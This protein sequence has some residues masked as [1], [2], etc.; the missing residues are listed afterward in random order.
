MSSTKAKK[1]LAHKPKTTLNI[2]DKVK[3]K[4]VKRK[5]KKVTTQE[6]ILG[7]LGIGSTLI[8]GVSQVA[9]QQQKTEFVSS[10]KTQ[11]G[12]STSKVR[13]TL[14]K[15][16]KSSFGIPEA[17][18]DY[19][20]DI[21]AANAAREAAYTAAAAAAA[22]A[23]AANNQWRAEAEAGIPGFAEEDR[24][25]RQTDIDNAYN[26]EEVNIQN[27]YNAAAAAADA[28]Y[29]AAVTAA[30]ATQAQIDAAAA[31]AA[32]AAAQAAAAAAAAQ[33]QAEALAAAQAAAVAAAAAAAANSPHE[34]DSGTIEGRPAHYHML[35]GVMT[36]VDDQGNSVL[37]SNG[38][39]YIADG[40]GGW[41]LDS[42][43]NSVRP[44]VDPIL[45]THAQGYTDSTHP[46]QHWNATDLEGHGAWANDE[47]NTGPHEND[48]GTIDV[49][50]QGHYHMLNGIM[51]LVDDQ[52]NRVLNPNGLYYR[53]DGNGGWN[54]D[55]IQDQPSGPQEGQEGTID[56]RLAHYH[57]VNGVMTLV[58]DAGHPVLNP[59]GYYYTSDGNNGWTLNDGQQ[60]TENGISYHSSG[61]QWVPDQ[62]AAG[63]PFAGAVFTPVYIPQT[64]T[65]WADAFNFITGNIDKVRDSVNINAATQAMNQVLQKYNSITPQSLEEAQA[66]H[67]I[68]C[69]II[70]DLF[71][72]VPFILDSSRSS[73]WQ[74]VNSTYLAQINQTYAGQAASISGA[75][76]NLQIF[77]TPEGNRIVGTAEWGQVTVDPNGNL[78]STEIDPGYPPPQSLLD[79]IKTGIHFATD[80]VPPVATTNP[81]FAQ[82]TVFLQDLV[83]GDSFNYS[84]RPS[85]GSGNFS[86]ALDASNLPPGLSLNASTGVISGT[87]TTAGGYPFTVVATDSVS[88]KTASQIITIRVAARAGE[89]PTT[90]ALPGT[91][92]ASFTLADPIARTLGLSTTAPVILDGNV[93]A[94]VI[95]IGDA[96]Y[97]FKDGQYV[98]I[99][100]AALANGAPG[101]IMGDRY[102]E[103]QNGQYVLVAQGQALQNMIETGS[104]AFAGL[105]A[106]IVVANLSAA[107]GSAGTGLIA[108]VGSAA[109]SG[110][111]SVFSTVGSTLG[112]GAWGTTAAAVGGA[113]IIGAA[114]VGT[115][116][117][118]QAIL[119]RGQDKVRDTHRIEDAIPYFNQ[120]MQQYYSIT[121]ATPEEARALN[122]A[123]KNA[124]QQL[125]NQIPFEKESSKVDQQRWLQINY[126][127]PLDQNLIERNMAFNDFFTNLQVFETPTGTRIA[128]IGDWGQIRVDQNG[129]LLSY[130]NITNGPPP[131]SVL[132]AIQNASNVT[133]IGLTDDIT[134][135]SS[136]LQQ[137]VVGAS[138]SQILSVNGGSGPF[139][140]QVIGGSLPDG[141]VLSQGGTISGEPSVVGDFSFKIQ[142]SD[143]AGKLANKDFNI[144]VA[145]ASVVASPIVLTS[146][147]PNAIVGTAYNGRISASGGSG[148][149]Y[150]YV[151]VGGALP[152][153]LVFNQDGTITG[154]TLAGPNSYSFSVEVTDSDQNIITGSFQ[155]EVKSANDPT[156]NRVNITTA[157]ILPEPTKNVAYSAT[158]A[159]TGGTGSFVYSLQSGSLP[160]GLS[161]NSSS[162]TISGTPTSTGDFLFD[163]KVTDT[164]DST[165]F[166][167]KPFRI[168]VNPSAVAAPVVTGVTFSKAT[169]ERGGS[170]TVSYQGTNLQS[171]YFDVLVTAPDGSRV[172]ADNWQPGVKNVSLQDALGTFTITG[173]RAHT[174]PMVHSGAFQNL[175]ASI[176]VV[177]A[178]GGSGFGTVELTQKE[179]VNNSPYLSD[180]DGSFRVGFQWQLNFRGTAG[181]HVYVIGG[182]NGVGTITDGGVIGPDGTLKISGTFTTAQIGPWQEDWYIGNDPVSA[183]QNKIGS[184]AFRITDQALAN[185]PYVINGNGTKSFFNPADLS[186]REEVDYFIRLFGLPANTPVADHPKPQLTPGGSFVSK[187]VY[188]VTPVVQNGRTVLTDN[189]DRSFEIQIQGQWINVGLIRQVLNSANNSGIY[190]I[191]FWQALGLNMPANIAA[192]AAAQPP[193]VDQ[194][195]AN[196]GLV[197]PGGSYTATF[198]GSNLANTYF[199]VKVYVGSTATAAAYET[200]ILNWQRGEIGSHIV[201]ANHPDQVLTIIAVRAHNLENDHS[202]Q[203]VQLPQI[204]SITITK[205]IPPV[206]NVP[207]SQTNQLPPAPTLNIPTP[208]VA[209]PGGWPIGSI[210]ATP[211]GPVIVGPNGSTT[212]YTGQTTSASSPAI[213]TGSNLGNNP[214]TSSPV[215]ISSI[216]ARDTNGNNAN[217]ILKTGYTIEIGGN[218]LSGAYSGF[219]MVIN[220]VDVPITRVVTTNNKITLSPDFPANLANNT[221]IQIKLK[222]NVAGITQGV[223]AGATFLYLTTAP[224]GTGAGGTTGAGTGSGSTGSSGT[225]TGSTGSGTTGSGTG[226]GSGTTGSGSTGSGPGT[227]ATGTGSTGTGTGGTGS[228]ST[229]SGTGTSGSGTGAGTGSTGGY[230]AQ[231]QGTY[232]TLSASSLNLA[233]NGYGTVTASVL[234]NGTINHNVSAVTTSTNIIINVNQSSGIISVVAVAVGTAN[235]LV[236]P[237]NLPASDVS[238]DKIINVFISGQAGGGSTGGTG[239]GSTGGGTSGTGGT[240]TGGTTSTGSGTTSGTGS[241]GS[242]STGTGSG[243]TGGS[244][245]SGG[246]TNTSTAD[247]QLIAQLQSQVTNLQ[248]R[249]N[250]LTNRLANQ[251]GGGGGTIVVNS[252]DAAQLTS[253]QN[254]VQQL[255]NLVQNLQSGQ[256][257]FNNA[258]VQPF[259][260]LQMPPGYGVSGP[261]T[262][263]GSSSGGLQMPPGYGA[264]GDNSAGQT[265]ETGTLATYKVKKGDNLWNI[266]KKYYGSGAQWRKLLAAN[267]K[268][269]S[270]PGNTRTLRIGFVLNIPQ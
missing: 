13:E 134:I 220:G 47:V 130:E 154:T 136:A 256:V 74:W 146:T 128:S 89:Q 158:I 188:D 249:I 10:Q 217:G 92:P 163:I 182:L 185:T 120:I 73:Q 206:S 191:K 29:S 167:S 189:G 121:P 261:A 36:L 85:G 210:I 211:A 101:I 199:D 61:G 149:G 161:L 23:R 180:N 216:V 195:S 102:Y 174:D 51:T 62:P 231:V 228:G 113:T 87:L 259:Q 227:G 26:Q 112:I 212:P 82:A 147:L 104:G 122:E 1:Y 132:R 15:I 221:V 50:R 21:A 86:F 69:Q 234:Y 170:Y 166:A 6:K 162:G 139:A 110:T 95:V 214:T 60:K 56:T 97:Q 52:G 265:Q 12:S 117:V 116:V 156:A 20:S 49:N 251:S 263:S 45:E 53:A 106:G 8:G 183:L 96:F 244:G 194:L 54:L 27:N 184:L 164:T 165:N 138:Y 187:Y 230:A 19:N 235:I 200:E 241:G 38:L 226:T 94:S 260:G 159:A 207:G 98:K 57:M 242:G 196:T 145:E 88:Q 115:I 80:E 190:D 123:A 71:N 219:A 58:E 48:P 75:L 3:I 215:I 7:G 177:A 14:R 202:G 150:S 37:N 233:V 125:F 225:G 70:V 245:N 90:P 103:N 100:I 171:A 269:L 46:G 93:P 133:L 253:L 91:L 262:G 270:M 152:E 198:I 213:F 223:L 246:T 114:V 105:G 137:G 238:Q 236:H 143:S 175:T 186:S 99:D 40:N 155:F 218:N 119:N 111:F 25:Q 140:W 31:A 83:V 68:A 81:T 9:P 144:T 66:N 181:Q 33:A 178:A 18:A 267:P 72:Q 224:A 205:N 247:Q 192:A 65:N 67:D 126:F 4:R 63:N 34:N 127:T 84:V 197:A 39:W 64:Y 16:F 266:A 173:V 17:K 129:N 160:L 243:G 76:A 42:A 11:K 203:Y 2:M 55:A 239:S 268:C 24:A 107:A 78:V 250:D 118:I 109:L 59:N 32:Q 176:N 172:E 153:G 151:L 204:I 168:H 141:L 222:S 232:L 237:T 22:Q 264:S 30:G 254:Q 28:A 258:P 148:S 41:T 255:S 179:G 35:N 43:K 240:G 131:P 252:S 193:R 44:V 248:N 142:V 5:H 135:I 169:V 77:K 209:P 124:I 108:G 208:L 201:D 229:G 257:R 79:A 157:E